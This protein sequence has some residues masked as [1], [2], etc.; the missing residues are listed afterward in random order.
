MSK[1]GYYLPSIVLYYFVLLLFVSVPLG[2]FSRHHEPLTF[3][4]PKKKKSFIFKHSNYK[5]V[6]NVTLYIHIF[7]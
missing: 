7:S 5:H 3:T 6:S 2:F 1:K 4:L